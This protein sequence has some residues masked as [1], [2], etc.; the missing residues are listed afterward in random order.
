MSNTF[1]PSELE[2]KPSTGADWWLFFRKFLRHGRTIAS[3]V[4]SSV[5]LARSLL[6]GIDVAK[7]QTIVELGAGTGP[8][9][10]ELLKRA[11]D[12]TRCIVI[13]RDPDFCLRLRER[14]PQAEI[15]EADANDL[16]TI[17]SER[18][19]ESVDHVLCGLP[20]PSFTEESR[21]RVM[22]CV[23]NYLR[24]EGTFR[25][26]THFPWVYRRL[27]RRYFAQVK[28]HM[29]FRNLPPAGFYVCRGR[30]I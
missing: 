12:Q 27:Y 15:L 24:A 26:L 17:L 6:K 9:T 13:E 20:L 5:W 11:S 1:S 3:F 8:I 21:D 23:L 14:F 4:P 25:Q 29:V 18:G 2:T 19:I 16:S 7:P 30:E 10:A 28:Y 22:G